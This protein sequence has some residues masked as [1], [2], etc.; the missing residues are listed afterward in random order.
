MTVSF[1]VAA[2]QAEEQI[3]K[4]LSLR[5]SSFRC[6]WGFAAEQVSELGGT[7]ALHARLA[8]CFQTVN[9]FWLPDA[10]VPWI[11]PLPGPLAG[12]PVLA[13]CGDWKA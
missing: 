12:V 7:N 2:K 6:L 11:E 1:V 10:I 8:N 9:F 13:E 5:S 3:E 4:E